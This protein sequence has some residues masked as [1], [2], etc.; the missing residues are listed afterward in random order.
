MK[1]LLLLSLIGFSLLSTG[2][3]T[4]FVSKQMTA[5]Y[6]GTFDPKAPAELVSYMYST[7][8]PS[9]GGDSYK[10]FLLNQK[11]QQDFRN[12]PK[13]T[14]AA[15]TSTVTA[16]TQGYGTPIYRFTPQGNPF[17]FTG[18]IPNDNAMAISKDGILCAA[19]NSVFWAKDLNTGEL[20]MPGPLGIRSLQQMAGGSSFEN[21]Y[22]PKLIYDPTLDRF[23]LVFLKDNDAANSRIIVCFSSSNDPRDPWNIY[24][25]DG[26]PLNNNRWTD[27]PAIA[28]TETGLVVTANLIIP[29]V[30]WQVGFD[31]SVIW[32]LDKNAGFA[33]NDVNATVYTQIKHN[34]TFTRNLHPVR[35]HD[36]ISDRLQFL[37][38]RNFDLQNDTIFLISLNEGATD[39]TIS[40]KALIASLP[41]GVPPNGKQ[42]DT[43]TTDA[44]KGLQ[45]N[46][47]RVLG[48]IQKDDWIQFVSTTAHG[49]NANAGIYHGF[50]DGAT[51][52]TPKVRTQV[53]SHPV[54]DYGYPNIAWSGVHPNQIQCLIGFNFTSADGHPGVAAVQLGNDT[55]FSDV[56]L[57]K[58]GTTHVDRHSDSYERW[59]DY[60]SVQNKFAADGSLI[61]SEV[62][63]AGFYGDGPAQNRTWIAQV[64]GNDTI[65]PL[66]PDGGALFPNPVVDGVDVTV[67]FNLDTEQE[68]SADLFFENGQFI[69]Q[70]SARTL[71]AGPAE[72]YLDMTGLASGVY[73]IRVQGAQG[74]LKMERIVKL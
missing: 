15:K 74:I 33:G 44:A 63:M 68:V 46:D 24:R 49:A 67:Q 19:V 21:Y 51:S 9:P 64:F 42:A 55:S 8:A 12:F 43:D 54:R 6:V 18:G 40:T 61:P 72:L 34:G 26:N 36:N 31:G 59:G 39:T 1:K 70:L 25:L 69:Q 27:F 14:S 13:P 65:V 52:S 73:I 58:E 3:N 53:L 10:S 28:L 22:D 47:A 38:N 30:S 66:H 16:P 32:H 4:S 56:V 7:S 71:P 5:E 17:D 11:Q 48:A 35:G 57:L 29:N 50:I 41:Y 23:V 45:T 2:Q 60:F 37:S 62:W 20:L